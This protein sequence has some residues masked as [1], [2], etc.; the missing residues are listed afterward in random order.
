MEP[1]KCHHFAVEHELDAAGGEAGHRLTA[2]MPPKSFADSILASIP[3]FP[4]PKCLWQ[5][6]ADKQ[7][8]LDVNLGDKNLKHSNSFG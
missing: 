6:R 2:E 8:T 7:S 5:V 3:W 1:T 4:Q